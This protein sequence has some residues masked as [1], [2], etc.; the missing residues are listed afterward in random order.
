MPFVMGDARS[1][2]LYFIAVTP[3]RG[4]PP[5]ERK[6]VKLYHT[7]AL[8]LVGWYLMV[9][10]SSDSAVSLS[11]WKIVASFDSSEKC[12]GQRTALAQTLQDPLEQAETAKE[13]AKEGKVWNRDL[14]LSR[15]QCAQCIST[16]DLR[17][18]PN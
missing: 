6:E 17:L 1:T 3:E 10:P 13:V 9:P 12:E 8:A 2:V 11:K 16:D 18:K 7:A 14:A 15:S 4:A 5:S